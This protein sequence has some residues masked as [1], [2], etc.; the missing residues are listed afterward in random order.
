MADVQIDNGHFTQLANILLEKVSSAKLNGCQ[1][2]IILQVWRYTYGFKRK[3]HELSAGFLAKATGYN[4]R[5]IQRDLIV[6]VERN[7]IIQRVINGVSRTLSFNKNFDKWDTT[8][9][10]LA[11]GEKAIGEL[12]DG[13]LA[14]PPTA[15]KTGVTYGELADQEIKSFK[16]N[17]KESTTLSDYKILEDEV[18]KLHAKGENDLKN[19]EVLAMHDVIRLGIPIPFIVDTMKQMYQDKVNKQEKVKS[20]VYYHQA[21][22]ERFSKP[23]T[24]VKTFKRNET[25]WDKI[26]KQLEDAE[27]GFKTGA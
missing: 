15:N 12:T 13:E 2:A 5:Q 9:G 22:K 14:V 8:Y 24:T 27:R 25:D 23:L 21:I 18:L 6:L 4:Q 17:V 7:I 26:E 10:E 3:E 20:F 1:H 16:Q 19:D 11:D